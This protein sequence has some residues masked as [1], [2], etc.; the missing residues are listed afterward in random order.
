MV[1]E[2]EA[3]FGVYLLYNLNPK[4]KGRVYIGKTTDPNRRI[5]QHNTGAKAGGAWKT[6]GKG[7]WEMV[8][9]IHGFPEAVSALR[10]EWAWQHPKISRRIR[11]LPAKRK[12][13]KSYDFH[14]RVVSE[15]LRTAPWNRL[16]LTIRWLNQEFRLDFSPTT[17]PPNHMP[18][19][20]GPIMCKKVGG[21]KKKTNE[22][23]GDDESDSLMLEF[24]DVCYK[25]IQK[26]DVKLSC[27]HPECFMKSHIICLARVFLGN[28]DHVIPIEGQCPKC[29]AILMW[30]E[31][32]RQ[33]QGCHR[34][35][36]KEV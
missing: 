30:G 34:N 31:L 24:C 27:L 2:V 7:P 5:H 32:V 26:E 36:Q 12:S 15:M 33:R 21:K 4:Y 10:F 11:H 23:T 14:F 18:I 16:A 19:E 13:E 1:Q 17:P 22:K 28:A 9:I 6:D 8:L 35:L 29:D 3:F 20:F 25:R